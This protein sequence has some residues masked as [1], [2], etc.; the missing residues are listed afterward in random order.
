MRVIFWGTR[1]SFAVPGPATLRYGGNTTCL[2]I[3]PASGETV[4]VDA[5]SGLRELGRVLAPGAPQAVHLLITHLHWDHLLGFLF[6]EPAY[7]SG[8]EVRVAG[9]PQALEGL[10]SLFATQQGDGHFPV[11]WENLPAR[12]GPAPGLQPPR[13]SL[14][15]MEVAT[16]PLNHPQGGIGFRFS[17]EGRDLVFLTDNELEG[18]GPRSFEQFVEFCRGAEVLVHDAQFLPEE[19][20]GRRGWGHSDYA[21]AVRLAREAGAG[22]L[23]LFHHDPGRSDEGVAAIERRAQ[24]LAGPGLAVTAAREGQSLEI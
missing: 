16:T 1:G 4:V 24:E 18:P 5:G 9:W 13:F 12:L 22:R 19:Q 14:G 8:W 7:L 11:S 15:S 20:E 6:F 2:Q 23:L 3:E 10:R 17:E 21:A